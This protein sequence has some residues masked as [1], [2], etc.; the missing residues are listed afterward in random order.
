ME[1]SSFVQLLDDSRIDVLARIYTI[2]CRIPLKGP[3]YI[4]EL[5]AAY[6]KEVGKVR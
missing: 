4:K 5:M 6:V 2:L 3:R 1:G